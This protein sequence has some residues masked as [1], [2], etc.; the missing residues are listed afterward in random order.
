MNPS[1]EEIRAQLSV[2]TQWQLAE[3]REKLDSLRE[4]TDKLLVIRGLLE[5]IRDTARETGWEDT[6]G[7]RIKSIGLA[8]R[9][10]ERIEEALK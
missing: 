1:V 6:G 8:D 9:M 4:Q 3:F 5:V 2:E 7:M 10:V